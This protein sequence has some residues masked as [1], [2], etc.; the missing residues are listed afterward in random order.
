MEQGSGSRETRQNGSMVGVVE[1]ERERELVETI[2][3][4]AYTLAKRRIVPMVV[5]SKTD[6]SDATDFIVASFCR[7]A[8]S[9]IVLAR[10]GACG[11]VRELPG[12]VGN[13][14]KCGEKAISIRWLVT[15]SYDA[16]VPPVC[17]AYVYTD[18]D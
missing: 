1:I 11:V 17:V 7:G 2:I 10:G 14:I 16:D 3:S 4:G 5:S 12:N 6:V 13:L 9:V 18:T 8:K 15:Q